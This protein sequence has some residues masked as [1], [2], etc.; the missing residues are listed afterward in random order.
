[1]GPPFI[2]L[3]LLVILIILILFFRSLPKS[4]QESDGHGHVSASAA[5]GSSAYSGAGGGG[6]RGSYNAGAASDRLTGAPIPSRFEPIDHDHKLCERVTIN[7]S[8][9]RFE[10]QLRTLHT[11]PDTLLGDPNR[12]IRF[13]DSYRN[14]YFFDRSESLC[15]RVSE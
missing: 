13:Y 12:R 4:G 9:L 5:L 15:L 11:F 1:M 10:T 14:E 6:R 7:V 8:G 2:Y 3:I